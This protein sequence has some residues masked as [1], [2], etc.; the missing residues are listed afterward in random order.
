MYSTLT[1]NKVQEMS[2]CMQKLVA[3]AD[4]DHDPIDPFETLRNFGFKAKSVTN[5]SIIINSFLV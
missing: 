5:V 2:K 4:E 3:Q 1:T